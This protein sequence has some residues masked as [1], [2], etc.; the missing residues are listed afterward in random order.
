MTIFI[1]LA[2]AARTWVVTANLLFHAD[3]LAA[4]AALGHL[5]T[6]ASNLLTACGQFLGFGLRQFG[7]SHLTLLLVHHGN[8]TLV[9]E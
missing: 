8:A 2:T 5:T 3:R 6:A 4:F 7:L 9:Q 1:F